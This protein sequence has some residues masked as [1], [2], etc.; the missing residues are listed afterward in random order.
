[1]SDNKK[2]KDYRKSL[3]DMAKTE[4]EEQRRTAEGK[5]AKLGNEIAGEERKGKP[6]YKP[7]DKPPR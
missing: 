1:M 6:E 7:S 3:R 4:P 5:A 2:I